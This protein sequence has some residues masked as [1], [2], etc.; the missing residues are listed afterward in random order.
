[1]INQEGHQEKSRL[2]NELNLHDLHVLHGYFFGIE[3]FHNFESSV[4]LKQIMCQNQQSVMMSVL[5]IQI[6]RLQLYPVRYIG[7]TWCCSASILCGF[8]GLLHQL[9]YFVLRY[10]VSWVAMSR[11]I[12]NLIP[13]H[14]ICLNPWMFTFTWAARQRECC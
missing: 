9:S 11:L 13:W 14:K 5:F 7:W 6:K 2:I 10:W 3:C 4:R 1:M 8:P 12:L